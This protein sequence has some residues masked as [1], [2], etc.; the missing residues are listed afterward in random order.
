MVCIWC[1]AALCKSDGIYPSE[2]IGKEPTRWFDCDSGAFKNCEK[3]KNMETSLMVDV[4]KKS[5][6]QT[7]YDRTGGKPE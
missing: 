2:V 7:E 3:V 4:T 1:F 6:N 5:G